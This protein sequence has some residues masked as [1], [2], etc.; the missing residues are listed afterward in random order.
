MVVRIPPTSALRAL[1]A[2]ARHLSF[3]LAAEE[4]HV[5]QSAVSHQIRHLEELWGIRL[6][7]RK[8]RG[9]ILTEEGHEVVPIIRDFI[10]RL[11]S[12]IEGITHRD[13]SE[14]ALKV[15][16]LQSFAFKWFVPR[17]GH[18]NA[19]CPGVNIWISTTDDLVDF[20]ME[21]ADVGIRLGY[22]NWDNLYKELLLQ[23]HVLPVCSPRFLKA[24]GQPAEPRDLLGYPL[25]RR[26]SADILQRWKDWFSDA[27]VQVGRIP[28]GSHFPQTSLALQAAID[29]QG[30]A[31]ARSAHVLDDL[32]AG[33]L[34]NL[35]PEIKSKSELSYY[36][37][38]LPGRENGPVISTF[39]AWLHREA[40]RSE[41]EYNALFP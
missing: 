25:L 8:G 12:A 35:F 15:T 22:G 27:G 33:R 2:S 40:H 23:E 6:F 7:K 20:S 21:D 34:V 3:T 13:E 14:N 38:C 10:R 4:L 30:V 19:E 9:L 16:L 5:T 29:D 41:E 26:Y 37:V 28:E 32:K 36:F 39:R 31:L 17:L 1:E 18:F 11:S 24:H